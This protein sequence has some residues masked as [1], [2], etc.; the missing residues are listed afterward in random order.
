MDMREKLARFI[1]RHDGTANICRHCLGSG[2]LILDPLG[3]NP[4]KVVCGACDGTGK[5]T[6]H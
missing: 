1:E 2:H 3:M 4:S 5:Q 6:V